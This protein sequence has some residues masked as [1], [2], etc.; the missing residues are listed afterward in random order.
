MEHTDWDDLDVPV[1][2]AIQRRTGTVHR[3]RTAAAGLNSQLA[4]ILDA[5]SG[6]GRRLS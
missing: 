6:A 3:V 5:A 4:L 2:E 1:R